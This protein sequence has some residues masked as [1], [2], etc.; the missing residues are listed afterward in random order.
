VF[1]ETHTELVDPNTHNN[2]LATYHSWFAI[3]FLEMS[4][5]RLLYHG[6]SILICPNVLCAISKF[7]LRAHTLKVEA[8]AWLED[9]S[10]VCGDTETFF[11]GMFKTL[12]ALAPSISEFIPFWLVITVSLILRSMHS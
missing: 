2:K 5:C 12:R 9:G 4:V 7:R 10:C 8:A 11:E 3:L 6:I 1:G